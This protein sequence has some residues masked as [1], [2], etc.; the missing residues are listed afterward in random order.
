MPIDSMYTTN[1]TLRIGG[2]ASGLDVDSIVKDLMEIEQLKVDRIKQQ[3]QLI[4]WRKEDYREISGLLRT[5]QDEFFN[6]IKP[7][8]YML[9]PNMY[10]T[11]Q[12]D[13]GGEEYITATA[14]L[15]N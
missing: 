8:T 11:F 6:I 9:S 12:A 1:T 13:S 7:E 3:Q 14:H 10:K 2:L 4:E 5:F 15:F